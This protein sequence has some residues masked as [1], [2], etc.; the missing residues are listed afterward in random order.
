M[1]YVKSVTSAS[2]PAT[3]D[4][5]ISQINALI[6]TRSVRVN[7]KQEFKILSKEYFSD[8]IIQTNSIIRVL[9]YVKVPHIPTVES[10]KSPRLWRAHIFGCFQKPQM[11]LFWAKNT[12]SLPNDTLVSD[13]HIFY[14]IF[15][16][17][18]LKVFSTILAL[19]LKFCTCFIFPSHFRLTLEVKAAKIADLCFT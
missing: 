15:Y 3:S 1:K 9:A 8:Y 6:T 16:V 12:N 17:K 10:R 7:K 2:N 5:S 4:E 19:G 13:R 14:P 18:I 11:S